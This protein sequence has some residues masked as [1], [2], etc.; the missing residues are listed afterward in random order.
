M[1]ANW[2]W[3]FQRSDADIRNEWSNYSNWPYDYLPYDVKNVANIEGSDYSFNFPKVGDLSDCSQNPF[4][5]VVY[6]ICSSNCSPGSNS[7]LW[8]TNLSMSPEYKV[9]NQKNI[10]INM[11]ILLDG[12]YRED[13]LDEGIYNYIE[14]YTRTSG[15]L[16]NGIYFYNFGLTTNPYDF[17]P[18]GAMNMSKFKNIQLEFTTSVPP[19]DPCAQFWTICDPCG[20]IIGVNKADWSIYKYNYNLYIFEERYNI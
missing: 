17:Q 3:Y 4:W 5:Q 12:K 20:G 16:P 14:K 1:V 15:N 6:D 8:A 19:L 11:G 2:M 9:E 10:L 18:S 7:F 13:V